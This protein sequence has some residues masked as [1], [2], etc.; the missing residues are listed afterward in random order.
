[1]CE[2][3]HT[4]A[5]HKPGGKLWGLEPENYIRGYPE[6]AFMNSVKWYIYNTVKG[7]FGSAVEMKMTYGSSTKESR[8][9]LGLE[10]SHVNDA[11]AMGKFHPLFR[12]ETVM[13]QKKRRN[14]R[15]LSKFYDAKYIDS[16]DGSKKSGKELFNGRINRNHKQDSEN[17]HKYRGKKVSKG[18]TAV[19]RRRYP[20]QPGDLILY[21]GEVFRTAGAQ[22]YG[23]YLSVRGRKAIKAKH[24][25]IVKYAGGWLPVILNN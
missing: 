13:Y 8:I 9:E 6:P 16:R 14:N 25:S 17:L 20:Y 18:R 10:K 19:R 1:M 2:T 4:P 7:R 15:V 22:H 11:Y 21:Q 12:A 3:C 24:V 5:N 23:E